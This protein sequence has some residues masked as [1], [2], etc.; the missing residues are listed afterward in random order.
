MDGIIWQFERPQAL[1]I[2][3]DKIHYFVL[4]MK[5]TKMHDMKYWISLVYFFLCLRVFVNCF[6]P[7]VMVITITTQ[8]LQDSLSVV[9]NTT[10]SY[11]APPCIP[12][13]T[14]LSLFYTNITAIFSSP[15]QSLYNNL[16]WNTKIILYTTAG[17]KTAAFKHLRLGDSWP[18]MHEIE[19]LTF[20]MAATFNKM[21][22]KVS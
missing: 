7:Y 6:P 14:P 17:M 21:L 20:W 8:N 12:A 11:L 19:A 9:I 15:Q 18:A 5:M 1:Y 10:A 3:I 4:L 22:I 2:A 13:P 16:C